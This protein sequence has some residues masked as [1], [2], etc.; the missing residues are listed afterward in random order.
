MLQTCLKHSLL[1]INESIECAN[2]LDALNRKCKSTSS[3]PQHWI[4]STI[5]NILMIQNISC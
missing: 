4:L 5:F 1:I 3:L 2:S